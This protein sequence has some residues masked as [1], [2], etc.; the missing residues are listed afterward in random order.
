MTPRSLLLLAALTLPSGLLAQALPL[1]DGTTRLTT[2]GLTNQGRMITWTLD[3]N[4][5]SWN[6]GDLRDTEY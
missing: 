2:T 4:F 1:A 5:S 3:F 6:R